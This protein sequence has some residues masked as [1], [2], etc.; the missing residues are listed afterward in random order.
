MVLTFVAEVV[1][2]GSA[3]PV[4][5]S[6]DPE[7]AAATSSFEHTARWV[8]RTDSTRTAGSD[9]ATRDWASRGAESHVFAVFGILAPVDNTTFVR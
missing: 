5:G 2:V 1:L 4:D 9:Q 8:S 6:E 7:G 3:F